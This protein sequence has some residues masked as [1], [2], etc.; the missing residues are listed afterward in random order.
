[1]EGKRVAVVNDDK[2][3]LSLMAE[4]IRERG[5]DPIVCREADHAYEGLKSEQPDVIVLDIRLGNP[6]AGWTILELLKLDPVTRTI[7]IIV[8]SAALS[9]LRSKADW[10]SA[11]GIDVLPKPFD[12]D[13]LY[14][15]LDLALARLE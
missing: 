5:W 9:D 12:I 2:V 4:L 6:D 8:C 3:F 1:M 10:L 11:R 15:R 7:P 14:E 13:D